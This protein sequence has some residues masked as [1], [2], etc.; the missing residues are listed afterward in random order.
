MADE[1]IKGGGGAKAF[2]Q[3]VVFV[4][5]V[6]AVYIYIAEVI[7]EISG[8]AH[9]GASAAGV[10][11]ELGREVF[12]GKGKCSTCHSLGTEGSAVRCPNLGIKE[13][14]PPPFDMPVIQRAALRA[15]EREKATG[16]KYKPIEYIIESHFT[17][18]AYVVDGFKNEMPTVWKPPIALNADELMSAESFLMSLG[19]EVNLEDIANSPIFAKMKAEIKKLE[20]DG[21]GGKAAFTPY[22]KG[23]PAKGAAIF[24]DPNSNTPCAKCHT[25]K[26]LNGEI[27]G[28]KVGPELTN[29]GG[30]R[31]PEYIVESV[32]DPSASIASGFEAVTAYMKDGEIVSGMDRGQDTGTAKIMIDT[33]EIVTLNKADIEELVVEKAS[34]M[35]GNFREI[36]TM[37]QFHDLL[38]FLF[39]LT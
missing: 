39:T 38:A 14:A 16:A 9:R 26:N 6:L 29:V 37:E 8:Q 19:G 23:D 31:T 3:S 36:L 21:G 25:A 30:T 4:L 10:G 5:C 32:M 12:F 22:I 20:G 2:G 27:M 17:P 35:P 33:G 28:G 13:G 18:S 11:P 1:E 7:T 15:A 34:T 24:F